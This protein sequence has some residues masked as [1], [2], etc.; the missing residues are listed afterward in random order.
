MVFDGSG[1]TVFLNKAL[2]DLNGIEDTTFIIEKYNVLSDPVCN[3][4][5][6]LRKSIRKAF[7]GE[8][9]K[10]PYFSAPIQELIERG[11][12]NEKP[13]ESAVME[14]YLSP[15]RDSAHHLFVVCV[16]IVKE[17]FRGQPEVAMA[18]AYISQNWKG[19]FDSG[20]TAKYLNISVTQLYRLFKQHAGITPGE[21]HRQCKIDYIKEKLSDKRLS[22]KEAFM[23]CG[24]DS[25]GWIKKVFK[26]V[27]GFTPLEWRKTH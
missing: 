5:M 14:V 18:K 27:T 16:F 20:K 12:I 11:I 9:V 7:N 2:L 3:D 22:I 25:Q 8:A 15:Y 10:V 1:K 21:F 24:E 4:Q 13:Y 26:D 19:K 23:A 6:K 17:I